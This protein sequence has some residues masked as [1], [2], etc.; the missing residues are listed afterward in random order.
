MHLWGDTQTIGCKKNFCN[1]LFFRVQELK[2]NFNP[3]S[4]RL[5]VS[6]IIITYCV[7]IAS[8]KFLYKKY[9]SRAPTIYQRAFFKRARDALESNEKN[10]FQRALFLTNRHVQY[11]AI[12]LRLGMEETKFFGGR[13]THCAAPRF[14]LARVFFENKIKYDKHIASCVKLPRPARRGISEQ[15]ISDGIICAQFSC[16][17]RST[18]HRFPSQHT[19]YSICGLCVAL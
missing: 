3:T 19:R 14:A 18:R 15:S 5:I 9:F 16:A 13:K 4:T 6:P 10:I 11:C 7:Q 8:L 12:L 2:T 1:D 17:S